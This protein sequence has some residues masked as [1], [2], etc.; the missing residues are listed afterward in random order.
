MSTEIWMALIGLLVIIFQ[1][2]EHYFKR[3]MDKEVVAS[4]NALLDAI[5]SMD[6]GLMNIMSNQ[7]ELLR[8][9]KDTVE[10]TKDIHNKFDTDGAPI[11][12]V[13]RSW[14]ETQK[15]IVEMLREISNKLQRLDDI[16]SRLDR[17]L[18]NK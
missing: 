8:S 14:S 9:V 18:N 17:R 13:P 4:N 11:W 10:W 7:S 15:E 16:L 3:R 1:L 5:K 2:I 6:K 12:Y